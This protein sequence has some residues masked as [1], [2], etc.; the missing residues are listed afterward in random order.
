M[1]N[2]PTLRLRSGIRVGVKTTSM[3][4]VWQVDMS[5]LYVRWVQKRL[6]DRQSM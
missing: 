3:P 4:I 6:R 1:G 2:V 5:M